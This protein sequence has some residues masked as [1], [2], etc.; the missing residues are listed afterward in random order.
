MTSGR[1]SVSSGTWTA[2]ARYVQSSHR[3]PMCYS[4]SGGPS[5]R[6]RPGFRG[7]DP[8]PA[9][10][11]RRLFHQGRRGQAWALRRA[12]AQAGDTGPC[13]PGGPAR[14]RDDSGCSVEGS[15]SAVGRPGCTADRGRLYS[16]RA[17]RR[18][19]AQTRRLIL[20]DRHTST[21][22]TKKCPRNLIRSN[23]RTR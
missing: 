7:P 14:T 4:A 11:R 5:L 20:Q 21:M 19:V 16:G 2:K 18:R 8:A 3:E 1:R 22:L 12:R 13:G 17:V 10:G 9:D 6:S 15:S 23:Y